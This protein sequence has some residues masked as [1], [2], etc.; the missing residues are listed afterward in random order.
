MMPKFKE[1]QLD[2]VFFGNTTYQYDFLGKQ[3]AEKAQRVNWDHLD[4][5]DGPR[6]MET[7]YKHNFQNWGADSY[8]P[9]MAPKRT[10]AG[11]NL[12]FQAI[13]V[14]ASDFASKPGKRTGSRP[15]S[16]VTA[17]N[18]SDSTIM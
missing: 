4:D 17:F 14:Y 12:P 18:A 5:T 9:N 7:Q 1:N 6:F 11:T 13:S 15:H 16:S 10:A 2:G 8:M 3:N